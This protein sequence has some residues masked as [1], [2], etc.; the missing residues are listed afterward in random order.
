[1][2]MRGWWL[3]TAAAV[4]VVAGCVGAPGDEEGAQAD[5]GADGEAFEPEAYTFEDT[6]L[7]GG[8]GEEHTHAFRVPNGTTEVMGQLAWTGPGAQLEFQ[9]VNPEGEAV[10]DGW[11]ES[12]D[13]RYVTTTHPPEPGRWTAV[14]T[15][16]QGANVPYTLD[17]EAREGEPYGSIER[18]FTIQPQDFAEV[19]LNMEP[20]DRFV[21][22]WEATGEVYFNVH[23]HD[24][25]ET[26]RPIE[27]TGTELE[28]N[29][30]AP[31]T[32]VYSPVWV[33]EG[34]LPVDVEVSI[35]GDYRLHSMTRDDPPE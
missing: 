30:S 15:A 22:A 26:D 34:P 24:D 14:V 7:A 9:L 29:F 33:N 6:F 25:G 12:E 1:M 35:D 18:T 21:F 11:A 27:H 5:P 4:I 10:A 28:G 19:N 31:V 23:Y 16:E 2:A 17:V 32:Q 20:G 8:T 3:I 13:H